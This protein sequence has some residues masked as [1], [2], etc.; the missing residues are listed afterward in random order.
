MAY[1]LPPI[2]DRTTIGKDVVATTVNITVEK[3][4][5]SIGEACLLTDGNWEVHPAPVETRP[6][7]YVASAGDVVD[8]LLWVDEQE[9]KQNEEWQRR[10]KPITPTAEGPGREGLRDGPDDSARQADW[11]ALLDSI[12]HPGRE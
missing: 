5:Y 6:W 11:E 1:K 8:A 12:C 10:H 7:T 4:G 9:R 2:V 3:D